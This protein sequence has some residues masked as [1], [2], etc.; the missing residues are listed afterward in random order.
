[1]T[2]S[3]LTVVTLLTLILAVNILFGTAYTS[4]DVYGQIVAAFGGVYVTT[5]Q[6]KNNEV[7]VGFAVGLLLFGFAAT[8]LPQATVLFLWVVLLGAII[9][10]GQ[11]VATFLGSLTTSLTTLGSNG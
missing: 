2:Q 4:G 11:N 3:Q 6:G 5:L 10:H 7:L 1:M 9:F 8:A